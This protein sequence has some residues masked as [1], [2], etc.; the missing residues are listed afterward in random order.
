[1]RPKQEVNGEHI[2]DMEMKKI[3]KYIRQNIC[4]KNN[5][6]KYSRLIYQ[7]NNCT[8]SFTFEWMKLK[9]ISICSCIV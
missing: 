3:R 8:L 9:F 1:M 2:N 6:K 7:K 4:I 5:L